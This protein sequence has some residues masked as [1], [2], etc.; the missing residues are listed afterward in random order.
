[1]VE[2]HE[3]PRL[4]ASV[5]RQVGR[6]IPVCCPRPRPCV[7]RPRAAG[8]R[9]SRDPAACRS[10]PSTCERRSEPSA[11]AHIARRLLDFR[12]RSP[13]LNR[14]ASSRA[15]CGPLLQTSV[16][17]VVCPSVRVCVY[18]YQCWSLFADFSLRLRVYSSFTTT[19]QRVRAGALKLAFHGT[20]TDTDTDT[21]FLADILARIFARMSA[22]RW[23]CHRNNFR[24]SR[25]VRVGCPYR[26]V[27]VGVVE[28]QLNTER[29]TCSPTKLMTDKL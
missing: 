3:L 9:A 29:R 24:K 18:I 8:G 14:I 5:E 23:A 27:G 2:V 25:V 28:C 26:G 20:D 22:C 4:G 17:S 10:S 19:W 11:D 12:R 7:G 15:R 21:D 6:R 1:M 16:R 13:L